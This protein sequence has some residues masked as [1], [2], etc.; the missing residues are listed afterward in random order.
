M[1][2]S[3]KV[4]AASPVSAHPPTAAPAAESELEKLPL[5]VFKIVTT[6]LANRDIKNL[7]LA[8]KCICRR[9]PLRLERVFLSANPRNVEV[10]LAIADHPVFRER[11]TEIVWDDAQLAK[12]VRNDDAEL[13]GRYWLLEEGPGLDEPRLN[14]TYPWWFKNECG[15]EMDV[16]KYYIGNDADRP[17]ILAIKSQLDAQMSLTKSW[18]HYQELLEQQD[19]VLE[20]GDD[21]SALKYGLTRFP[22]L[23]RITITPA[24]HGF[25]FYPLYET[26]MIRAFPKG[27]RYPIP[28]G[29]PMPHGYNLL[30]YQL[31]PWSD[32]EEKVKWRGFCIV[33]RELANLSEQATIPKLVLNAHHLH[34]GLNAHIFEERSEEYDNL[35]KVIERPGFTRLDLDLL[36]EQQTVRGWPCLRNSMLKRALSAVKDPHSFS[37][38]TVT[39]FVEGQ[40]PLT[41]E[42][43]IPPPLTFIPVDKWQNLNHFGL[44]RALVRQEDV[45]SLLKA[46]PKTLRSVELSFLHFRPRNVGYQSLVDGMRNT[47]GWGDRIKEERPKVIIRFTFANRRPPHP[48]YDVNEAVTKYIHGERDQNPFPN[49]T[50]DRP[51]PG[52]YMVH[53]A[54]LPLYTRPTMGSEELIRLGILKRE[55]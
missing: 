21:E 3:S 40:R 55:R 43:F 1:S 52:T 51:A 12:H 16:I 13:T 15:N 47:L 6:Y 10:F 38:R 29:W 50:F 33:T 19:Q 14:G 11:I 28:R 53:L 31:K 18:E 46:L 42:D 24:A 39:D 30:T 54:F 36:C 48:Y 4:Q 26:P 37:L 23:Q 32:E 2:A 8:S 5:E 44:S 7:R 22:S 20:T 27:F 25:L 34:T 35:V 17:D 9:A 45:L 49:A 41:E